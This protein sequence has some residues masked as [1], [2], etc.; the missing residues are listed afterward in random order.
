M[1]GQCWAIVLLKVTVLRHTWST[2]KIISTILMS[3]LILLG[4][5]G[6]VA[7]ALGGYY[8]GRVWLGTQEP[9]ISLVALD[10]IVTVFLFIWFWSL[11][12]EIQR[13]DVIDFKKMMFFPISLRLIFFLNFLT[14]LLSPA[15]AL[16][17]P[18]LLGLLLG[19]SAVQ[20]AYVLWGVPLALVFFLMLTA[21]AYYARGIMSI[22]MENKRRRRLILMILPLC[23]AV[24]PQAPNLIVHSLRNNKEASDAMKQVTLEQAERWLYYGNIAVPVGWMPYGVWSLQNNTPQTAGLC[25]LGMGGLAM[26]GLG[27]GYRSTVRHYRG[28]TNVRRVRKIVKQQAP[29]KPLTARWMPFLDED[30]AAMTWAAYLNYARHPNIRMLLIMPPIMAA[31]ILITLKTGVMKDQVGGDTTW[32]PAA[33]LV[34]PFFN[35][36]MVFFNF[37]GIDHAGFRGL[38]LLPTP[39]HKYILAKNMALFPFVAGMGLFFVLGGGWILHTPPRVI[40]ISIVQVLEFFLIYCLIGNFI[41]LYFPYRLGRDTMRAQGNRPILLL[42]GLCS[43]A[44][45]GL[46]MLPAMFCLMLDDFVASVWDYRGLPIGLFV[47]IG[48]LALTALAYAMALVHAGDLLLYRE[49]RILAALVKD[50]E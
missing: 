48:L 3:I 26:L 24:L 25:F 43:A 16:F 1:L 17:I 35:F 11:L 4:I 29:E 22:L 38:L 39:R 7:S 20:G 50:R 44:F 12:I 6:A 15:L 28:E 33:L 42:M 36:S 30:T 47:S 40:H 21:W 18:G 34:W 45:V 9:L 37:F 23:F 31:I 27:L 2:G 8:A 19:L 46:L 14:S 13:A 5:L 41:S 49:Q 32:L 10:G